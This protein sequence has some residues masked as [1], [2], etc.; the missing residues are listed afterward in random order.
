MCAL[1]RIKP[2]RNECLARHLAWKTKVNH[3]LSELQV[4]TEKLLDEYCQYSGV[5]KQ[6]LDDAFLGTAKED[7]I[8]IYAPSSAFKSKLIS[9]E[10]FYCS[11]ML[12]VFVRS[13]LFERESMKIDS[14]L[15][16]SSS[17][18]FLKGILASATSLAKSASSGGKGRAQGYERERPLIFSKCDVLF[19]GWLNEKK[20]SADK[21]AE[22]MIGMFSVSHRE[23]AKLIRNERKKHRTAH[24][25]QD[26]ELSE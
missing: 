10:A 4:K 14:V 12:L 8:V 2:E 3:S 15:E 13:Y 19:P 24:N 1:P 23:M 25:V 11:A 26:T 9:A 22:E 18:G 21:M 17:Y 7:G 16:W 5:T 20:P 6:D